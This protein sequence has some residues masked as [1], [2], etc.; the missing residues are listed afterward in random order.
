M[1][2]ITLGTIN[3][4]PTKGF[5][6]PTSTFYNGVQLSLP[7]I[8]N[9][10]ITPGTVTSG[11][12]TASSQTVSILTSSLKPRLSS[13]NGVNTL[14]FQLSTTPTTIGT[15]NIQFA[16]PSRTTAVSAV[17]DVAGPR[18][19]GKDAAGNVVND[20]VVGGVVSSSGTPSAFVQF[21]ANSTSSAHIIDVMV[22]YIS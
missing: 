10:T 15:Q 1:S 22:D 19:N 5:T 16:L 11:G 9:P 2:A 17:S 7:T 12:A 13:N 6:L 20:I 18:P 4:D 8:T 21:T 14:R 3:P